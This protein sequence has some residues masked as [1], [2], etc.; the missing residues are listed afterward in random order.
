MPLCETAGRRAN[1]QEVLYPMLHP[2]RFFPHV[3]GVGF[4]ADERRALFLSEFI[5]GI[6]HSYSS[7]LRDASCARCLR[8]WLI[9]VLSVVI[10]H[11]LDLEFPNRLTALFSR[12][13]LTVHVD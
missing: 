12:C 9:R 3:F 5:E 2:S 13:S 8:F 7:P 11:T 10:C 6:L 4:S 1:P